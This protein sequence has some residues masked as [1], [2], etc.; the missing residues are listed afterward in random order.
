MVYIKPSKSTTLRCT[1]VCVY[2]TDY[3]VIISPCD[4][5]VDNLNHASRRHEVHSVYDTTTKH[6]ILSCLRVYHDNYYYILLL[7]IIIIILLF[8]RSRVYRVFL[9]L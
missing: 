4:G 5:C 1:C 3:R 9:S 2:G 6:H 8:H 7:F